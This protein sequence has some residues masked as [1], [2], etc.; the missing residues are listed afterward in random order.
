[1]YCTVL[2]QYYSVLQGTTPVLLCTTKYYSVLQSTTPTL[3]QCY[4]VLHCTTPYH[5]VP[6]QHY[7]ALQ[8]TTPVLLCGVLL[9]TTKALSS[10]S[11]CYTV[12]L[13]APLC[14]LQ[15]RGVLHDM[16]LTLR[17]ATG[18][19]VQPHQIM[20]LPRKITR[21]LD[22]RWLACLIP[23][24]Y[25]TSFA[26]RRLTSVTLQPHQILRLPQ[27]PP[28]IWQKFTENS[29][30][31]HEPVSPQRAVQPRLLFALAT[32]ILYWKIQHCAPPIFPNSPNIA[33]ARKSDTW[34]SPSTAPALKRDTWTSPSTAPATQK[35]FHGWSPSHMERHLQCAE[36]QVSP[37]NLT[38]NTPA[39]QNDSHAW[40]SSHM[41]RHLQ[42]AEQQVSPS[43]LIKY[44]ACPAQWPPKI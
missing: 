34:T 43:N 3:L 21:M 10:A 18:V 17:G 5:K 12:L 36:L 14:A 38:K 6:L 13:L 44:C 11:L 32:S 42:C 35:G 28:K 37:S 1:M 16:S 23:V 39:P 9:C 4:S 30:S 8:S 15:R 41:T 2:L 25:E 19:I 26:L 20:R 33:P 24:T 22:S 27:W 29:R 31:E 7:A 40:S